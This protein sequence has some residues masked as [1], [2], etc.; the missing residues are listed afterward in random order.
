MSK[1]L[2]ASS[3]REGGRA[4]GK[5]CYMLNFFLFFFRH[6]LL[7][8]VRKDILYLQGPQSFLRPRMIFCLFLLTSAEGEMVVIWDLLVFMFKVVV[9]HGI[10]S[11]ATLLQMLRDLSCSV[12]QSCWKNKRIRGKVCGLKCGM[13]ELAVFCWEYLWR[14]SLNLNKQRRAWRNL[15]AQ[16]SLTLQNVFDANSISVSKQLQ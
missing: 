9:W 11:S 15:K 4:F 1:S 13:R 6:L 3:W 16:T 14:G 12:A 7:A 10:L 8:L 2:A 5:C